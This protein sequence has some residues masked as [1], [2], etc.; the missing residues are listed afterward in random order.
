MCGCRPQHLNTCTT[1]VHLWAFCDVVACVPAHK[2]TLTVWHHVHTRELSSHL[3]RRNKAQQPLQVSAMHHMC[4]TWH[5]FS[6]RV[7]ELAEHVDGL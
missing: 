1:D 4:G 2:A 3:S 7:A 6:Q 5:K